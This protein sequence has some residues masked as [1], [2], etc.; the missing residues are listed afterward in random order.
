MRFSEGA[1]NGRMVE[2]NNP[3]LFQEH[4]EVIVFTREEFSRTYMSIMERIDTITKIDLHLHQD[5]NEDWKLIS[6]WPMIMQNVH[7]IDRN[8][9]ELL[10]KE[11]SQSYLDAYLYTTTTEKDA[12]SEKELV[13][14][15]NSTLYQW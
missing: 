14:A 8:I 13:P 6:Y 2:L 7:R 15:E 10:K 5:Q 1:P 3:E 12:V 11:H 4:K 9:N